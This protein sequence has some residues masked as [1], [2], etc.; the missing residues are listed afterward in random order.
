[1]KQSV[2]TVLLI[3]LFVSCSHYEP[4]PQDQIAAL[5]PEGKELPVV[6]K[7]RILVLPTLNK[8][9]HGG[10]ALS[11]HAS[12]IVCDFVM[13]SPELLL[14][15]SL[16][17]MGSEEFVAASGLEYNWK[18]IFDRARTTGVIG[19]IGSSLDEL[20]FRDAGDDVGIFRSR[21]VTTGLRV[22]LELFD[23]GSEQQLYQTSHVGELTEELLRLYTSERRPLSYDPD[24]AKSATAKALKNP[25]GD[26]AP[27]LVRLGWS[28]R[29]A[30]ID[31]HRYYINTGEMSGLS[32]GQLLKVFSD[33]AP[34][35]DPQ[36]NIF[37]GRAPG[38]FK[39]ILRV[40][41][42]FGKDGA[43]AVL[44]SGANI[45]ELDRIEIYSSP[46]QP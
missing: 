44:H 4:L 28:G 45:K 2:I 41:D 18:L 10:K 46:G 17:V 9:P 16:D 15:K 42:F 22:H 27:Q 21:E 33:G 25:L 35:F 3:P 36:T 6:P 40:I 31:L 8:T 11:E 1:M 37:I 5:T 19:A 20:W 29:V 32:R 38:T 12:G 23:V 39:G 7:K 24:S 43:V 30:K 26:L 34:I 13:S 14:V